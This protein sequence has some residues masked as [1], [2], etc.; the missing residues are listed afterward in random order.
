MGE[1]IKRITNYPNIIKLYREREVSD[2]LK[3]AVA[4][5]KHEEEYLKSKKVTKGA[6]R[7]V[8]LEEFY[9]IQ[10]DLDMQISDNLDHATMLNVAMNLAST[11]NDETRDFLI[12][13]IN[14]RLKY[15]RPL[16]EKDYNYIQKVLNSCRDFKQRKYIENFL[17]ENLAGYEQLHYEEMQKIFGKNY[18]PLTIID[19]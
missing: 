12:S 10:Y 1:I 13:K 6:K 4:Y 18:T 9:K 5:T 19:D 8:D 16:T 7:K 14:Y 3:I 2:V 15:G 11:R 17:C